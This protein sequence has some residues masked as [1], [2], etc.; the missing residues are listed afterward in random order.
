M[1]PRRLSGTL[2]GYVQNGEVVY[3]PPA[4]EVELRDLLSN[5]EQDLHDQGETNPLVRMA[6]APAAK[7]ADERMK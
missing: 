6:V 1:S 7:D 2:I 3:T 4:G 5:W